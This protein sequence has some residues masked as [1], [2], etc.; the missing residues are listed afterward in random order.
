MSVTP[1]GRIYSYEGKPTGV[2]VTYKE[3]SDRKIYKITSVSYVIRS[4]CYFINFSVI[5]LLI[6]DRQVPVGHLLEAGWL[7]RWLG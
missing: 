1:V 5:H 4:R 7:G 3:V 6:G 2:S